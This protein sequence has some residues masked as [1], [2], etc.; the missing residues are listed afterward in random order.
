MDES[1]LT[2]IK[3]L[4]G[5]DE[6]ETHFDQDIITHINTA[7]LA[8]TQNGVGPQDGFFIEDKTATWSDF[9]SEP[10]KFQAV[11]TFIYIKVK[12]VFDPPP[13]AS[14]VTAFEQSADEWLWRLNVN[15][16]GYTT[17]L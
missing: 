8:L 10:K 9:I 13:S 17:I 12:L 4:L 3:K 5:P 2:S 15:A 1:I 7:I 14:L 6:E 11:K 16:E